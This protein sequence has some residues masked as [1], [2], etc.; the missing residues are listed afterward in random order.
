MNCARDTA[1]GR[2]A[3]RAHSIPE[4]DSQLLLKILSQILT[5]VFDGYVLSSNYYTKRYVGMT[6]RQR[7]L[8]RGFERALH[9]TRLDL[10]RT[11]LIA[12]RAPQTL[13]RRPTYS[14]FKRKKLHEKLH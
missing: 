1:R 9:G 5:A 6:A 4:P 14:P 11:W 8:R 2:H 12:Q 13:A 10:R 7:Q 3:S